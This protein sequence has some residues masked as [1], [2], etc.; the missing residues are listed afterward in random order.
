MKPYR[1]PMWKAWLFLAFIVGSQGLLGLF[2]NAINPTVAATVAVG[3]LENTE[4]GAIAMRTYDQV[5]NALPGSQL[6]TVVLLGGYLVCGGALFRADLVH[7]VSR[8]KKVVQ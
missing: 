2:D 3:Q 8:L 5:Q 4:G 6:F 7:L 1:F